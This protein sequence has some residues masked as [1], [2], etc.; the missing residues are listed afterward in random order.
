MEPQQQRDFIELLK[1]VVLCHRINKDEPALK[2]LIFDFSLIRDP[3]YKYSK[4]A[5]D[6]F[7]NTPILSFL[8]VWFA[9]KGTQMAMQKFSEKK[10]EQ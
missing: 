9:A 8:F 10:D 1:M 7:F 6:K 3:M 5:Q 4:K 2:N